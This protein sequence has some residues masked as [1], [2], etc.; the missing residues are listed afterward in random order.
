MPRTGNL[1]H[2]LLQPHKWER[3][4]A[5]R[6]DQSGTRGAGYVSAHHIRALKALSNVEIV[7]IADV[8]QE[9]AQTVAQQSGIP[10]AARNLAEM[11]AT[12]P[13]AVHILTPPSSHAD[14]AVEALAM[15]C[16]VLVEKPM[17][18]TVADCDRMLAAAR[19]AGRALSVNH[20]ARMD[21][22]VLK[23]LDM[24]AKNA[25][26]TV[27]AVDFFR[28][29]DYPPYR[30][31][32]NIPP[33]FRAG[34]YPFHDLG[35]HGLSLFEAFLGEVQ[36]ADICFAS[37]GLDA[38]LLF[39][40]WRA[41]V[42]CRRGTGQMYLSWNIRPIQ[43]QIVVHGTR[44]VIQVDCFLQTCTLRRSLPGPKFGSAVVGA[45]SSSFETLWR[46]PWNVLRFATGRLP[47]SPGIHA[48]I[49][50]FYEALTEG[51]AV[52]IPA[53]EGRR[54]V[55][56][57]EEPLRRADAEKTR[58]YELQ[59]M[60]PLSPVRVLVTGAG[61]FLGGALLRRL[62]QEGESVRVHAR[63]PLANLDAHP[64]LQSVYGDLGDPA[65]VDH[66]IQGVETV[67]HIGAA[68]KGSAAD[69]ERGTVWGT[70]NVIAA[71]LRHNVKRLVY[72]SS[73]SVLDQAGHRPGEPLNESFAYEP[74]PE[75]RGA[76]TQ[77]KLQAEQLVLEAVREQNLPAIVLRP[78][79]IFGPG[80]TQAPSGV[81]GLGGRWV[82]VG[83]GNL[84]L[85]LVYV[86]D[87][88]QSLLLAADSPAHGS[89][90]HIVDNTRVSQREYIELYR[91]RFPSELQV[92]YVPEWFL[93]AV[94]WACEKLP[95][96]LKNA[97]PLSRYR[98]R[99]IRPLSDLDISAAEQQL[100]WTPSV[101]VVDGLNR[102]FSEAEAE[103]AP[104]PMKIVS[105]A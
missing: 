90:F 53:E 5:S 47:G 17:A 98:V 105:V 74:F 102:T 16:H 81:I 83:R 57:M 82:V 25:V 6:K 52:P 103:P 2:R 96:A 26:G 42:R 59:V 85:P 13:D 99:S 10:L 14:L 11:A 100:G 45:I 37:S 66:A 21:P 32:P 7:A 33:Q 9:R 104:E 84:A 80:N 48:S 43:N 73:L 4:V 62:L 86:D 89:V 29:S 61:G 75:K 50:R 70:R 63:R 46:V 69:F 65:L 36:Q 38:N 49:Q 60:A 67:Y 20:S 8:D 97:V 18:G 19:R 55:A 101:G 44:G 87:V 31:G 28:S 71:C 76:Y 39:D 88:V 30:G 95:G 94:G 40:E 91:R 35:I 72:V 54:L 78:G 1:K 92:S 93:Y 51:N 22:S 34:S 79:Q 68:M 41:L 64:G 58:A 56:A 27:M 77:T 12:A 24:V 23:A 3:H 15:G